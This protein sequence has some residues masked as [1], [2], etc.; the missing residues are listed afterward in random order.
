MQYIPYTYVV[1]HL[2]S[3]KRYYG[4]RAANSKRNVANPFEL[5][6]TYFTTSKVVKGLIATDGIEAFKFVVRR[7]FKTSDE[8]F[9]WESKVLRR[10]DAARSDKW[11][12]LHVPGDKW[13]VLGPRTEEHMANLRKNHVAWNQGSKHSEG[14]R[15]KMSLAHK[16]GKNSINNIHLNYTKPWFWRISGHE[17]EMD[18]ESLSEFAK[19][20]GHC[21]SAIYEAATKR[22]KFKDLVITRV[23]R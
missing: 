16:Q 17:F 8:A 5:G 12:N 2:P 19:S 15:K 6:V 11:L 13:R 23:P 1:T 7:T 9:S 22:G 4:C 10:L 20:N 21:V 3:G 18:V 14:T